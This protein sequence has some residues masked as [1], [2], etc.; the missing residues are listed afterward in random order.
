MK[1]QDSEID[2]I[3][4]KKLKPIHEKLTHFQPI[5]Q[6]CNEIPE[7]LMACQFLR[8]DDCVLELG[9]SLG[10]NS[11]V[12]NTILNDKTKHVVIEPSLR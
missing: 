7:Q 11:C 12:I 3:V 1:M 8:E 4:F 6:L 2:E 5:E 10:R 9:G